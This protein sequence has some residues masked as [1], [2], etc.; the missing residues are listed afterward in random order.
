MYASVHSSII[1]NNQKVE[2]TKVFINRWMDKQNVVYTH[3]EILFSIKKG[4]SDLCYNMD[5]T[6]GYTNWNVNQKKT[7]TIWLHVCEVPTVVRFIDRKQ[8]G[9]FKRLWGGQGDG[10]LFNGYSFSFA[11]W[12]EFWRLVVQQC[13]YAQC[14]WIVHLKIK[15]AN[16]LLFYHN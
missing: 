8:N 1:Q 11:R 2:I 13:E 15:M 3:N 10:K 14:Y 5:D 12:K 9:G 16:F 6:R 4:D 7:N